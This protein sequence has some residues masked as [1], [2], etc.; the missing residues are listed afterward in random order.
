M[1]VVL[2]LDSKRVLGKAFD[3]S[4]SSLDHVGQ[5]YVLSLVLKRGDRCVYRDNPNYDRSAQN[6]H[7]Y[8]LFQNNPNNLGYFSRM[9]PL[10]LEPI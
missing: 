5:R 10:E 8:V 6:N 1:K 2:M 7:N 4:P 9:F 3:C